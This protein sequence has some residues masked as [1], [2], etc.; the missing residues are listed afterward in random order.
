MPLTARDPVGRSGLFD[1]LTATYDACAG[2]GRG[3]LVLLDGPVGTGKTEVLRIFV[4]GVRDRGGVV[5]SAG[6]SESERTMPLAVLE[7]LLD[8]P[9]LPAD[10]VARAAALIDGQQP[11]WRT[12]LSRQCDPDGTVLDDLCDSLLQL[13]APLP[14]VVAVDDAHQADQPSLRCLHRLAT[15][16]TGAAVLIVLVEST[17]AAGAVAARCL[18]GA[19]AL[20]GPLPVDVDVSRFEVSPLTVDGVAELLCRRE[21]ARALGAADFHHAVTGGNLVLLHAVLEDRR[22]VGADPDDT[23]IGDN[24]AEAVTSCLFRCD[25]VTLQVARATAVL[26][27]PAGPAVLARLLEL[28]QAAVERALLLLTS[29]GLL[30][31]TGRFRHPIGRSAALGSM[32]PGERA[33]M[34]QRIGHLHAGGG[35]AGTVE[36]AEQLVEAGRRSGDWMPPVLREAAERSLADGDL[37]RA[38]SL[39]RA[40][41]TIKMDDRQRAEIAATTANLRWRTNP[42]EVLQ[43]LPEL[44]ADIRAGRLTGRAAVTTLLYLLW[45]GQ[46]DEA[47]EILP[48]VVA[49]SADFPSAQRLLK[50][51]LTSLA[52]T[53]PGSARRLSDPAGRA[54]AVTDLLAAAR[55]VLRECAPDG[56]TFGLTFAALYASSFTADGWQDPWEPQ[57]P[58]SDLPVWQALTEAVAAERALRRGDLAAATDH[59]R[60]GLSGLGLDGWGVAVGWPISVLV[61]AASE[62]GDHS[63]AAG[64]LSMPVPAGMFSTPFG[65][66][67]L[68][69]RGR[70]HFATDRV[71]AALNDFYAGSETAAAWHLD[72][73]ELMPWRTELARAYVKL[74]RVGPS[75]V[76]I[77]QQ[78]DGLTDG[79]TRLRGAALRVLAATL[80]PSERVPV[81]RRAVDL[82]QCAGDQLEMARALADLGAAYQRTGCVDLARTTLRAA[83]QQA[84]LCGAAPDAP[85]GRPLPAEPAREA[86]HPDVA[87]LTDAERRVA[88]LA[89]KGYTNREIAQRLF[90]T[91]STVEQHLT[92]VYRKLHVVRRR[93]LPAWLRVGAFDDPDQGPA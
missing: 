76:L 84:R 54:D 35:S 12:Y 10:V 13:A 42:G 48:Q 74:D 23:V 20:G 14:L 2:S 29:G 72:L 66:R 81:L 38:R 22:A 71:H 19:D 11:P 50:P 24:F 89:V 27:S 69:A 88:A 17:T 30:D 57:L 44:L 86:D 91:V 61:C 36:A 26:R 46:L 58:A 85:K 8:R 63:A 90:L 40:A 83:E 75:Q 80:D 45:H 62:A 59:A 37:H 31:S 43:H 34:F 51:T 7:Q 78:L 1:A 53:Y 65:L 82:L 68:M 3:R 21:G 15:R 6:A 77:R 47:L 5:L 93:E 73:P 87:Q 49:V 60:R 56:D 28:D 79:Q 52:F 39:L 4:D 16:M 41:S 64:L 92:R 9:G 25:P 33:S 18:T 55:S 32:A 70:H 67:Y